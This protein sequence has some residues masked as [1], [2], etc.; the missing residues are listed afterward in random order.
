MP[1]EAPTDQWNPDAMADGPLPGQ[2]HV[3]IVYVDEDGGNRGEMVIDYEVLAGTTAEQEG[4]RHRDY[5]SK[6]PKAM[7]RIHQLAVA[8]GM[9]DMDVLRQMKESGK[10]PLYDFASEAM[11]KQCC[12]E[13]TSE[14]YQGKTRTKCGFGI[15]R[16]DDPKVVKWP[17]HAAM[18][19]KSGV[20]VPDE[21]DV[22]DLLAGVV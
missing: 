5:F 19:A 1:F 22:D 21:D 3:Q 9:V 20:A 18:L 15:Y 2:Y 17:K 7:G 13:L 14:E 12:V 11:N 4:K 10:S 6:T 8:C 16:L